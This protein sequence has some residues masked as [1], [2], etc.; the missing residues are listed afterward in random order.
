MRCP[1]AE[2][3]VAVGLI[4]YHG[5]EGVDHLIRHHARDSQEHVPEEWGND[6]VTEV[7]GKCLQGGRAN[8]LCRE[9]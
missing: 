8:L 5:V 7:L 1:A 4:A 3:A 6:A 9:R 2:V